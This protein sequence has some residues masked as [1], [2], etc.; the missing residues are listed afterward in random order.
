MCVD[1]RLRGQAEEDREHWALARVAADIAALWK[2]TTAARGAAE[3]ARREAEKQRLLGQQQSHKDALDKAVLAVV[4]AEKEI[5]AT[6]GAAGF[7][8]VDAEAPEAARLST[9]EAEKH[10]LLMREDEQRALLEKTAAEIAAKDRRLE[11]ATDIKERAVIR[12]E[13]QRLQTREQDQKAALEKIGAQ[14]VAKGKQIAATPGGTKL[15]PI[16]AEKQRLLAKQDRLN[17]EEARAEQTIFQKEQEIDAVKRP[18]A[19]LALEVEKARLSA[20]L[21]FVR[22][23]L[24][25]VGLD[26]A[27]KDREIAVLPGAGRFPQFFWMSH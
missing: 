26:I 15:G 6:P 1:C 27:A 8:P 11:A 2:A 10:R 20:Q 21:E 25:K 7:I 18:A 19:R 13:Q 5:G 3:R 14:I 16:I 9:L 17:E 24:T 22:K 12:D 23:Q 4:A